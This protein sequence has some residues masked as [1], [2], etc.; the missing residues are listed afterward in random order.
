MP[1][2]SGKNYKY[3]SKPV[4][5][6]GSN[7]GKTILPIAAYGAQKL[8]EIGRKYATEKVK[9]YYN[10]PP[11]VDYPKKKRKFKSIKRGAYGKF[12]GGLPKGKRRNLK[13]QSMSKYARKGSTIIRETVGTV[14]DPDSVYLYAHTVV[15]EDVLN[16][17]T[18]AIVRKIL[19]SAFKTKYT[20][21]GNNILQGDYSPSV[22]QHLLALT[23]YN[24]VTGSQDVQAVA[25]TNATTLKDVTTVVAGYFHDYS[26]GYGDN[27]A[28]NPREPFML[29]IYKQLISNTESIMLA[30]LN[31]HNE[32]IDLSST[33]ELKVQNRSLSASGGQDTDVIDSNP[34]QGYIYEFSSIPKSRDALQVTAGL[35]GSARAY[36]FNSIRAADGMN[37]IRG[38]QLPAGYREPITARTFTNCKGVSRIR[39]EP[40]HI[41]NLYRKFKKTTNFVKFLQDFNYQIDVG[42]TLARTIKMFGSGV[43]LGFED[44][45]NVNAAANI[46]VTY[47]AER[48]LGCVC[49]TRGHTD[50]VPYFIQS[51]YD[52]VPA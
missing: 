7:W 46:S 44:V 33:L 39:L 18:E 48:K 47:E 30:S 13:S 42:T 16:V 34:I 17:V 9:D 8:A 26:S 12:A 22:G 51:D 25:I 1:T 21:M 20:N 4:N 35:G 19:E 5:K 28:L 40:G 38:A 31:L 36:Q 14:S 23:Y 49:K 43:M 15:P 32:Y 45:I 52:N 50:I 11:V 2:R 41:K 6:P 37:L 29:S 27:S 3:M 10:R 24:A